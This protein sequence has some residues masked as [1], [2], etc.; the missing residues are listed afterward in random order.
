MSKTFV[1]ERTVK[2]ESKSKSSEDWDSSSVVSDAS[3]GSVY[4]KDE[5]CGLI[6]A[7]NGISS[8]VWSF[9]FLNALSISSSGFHTLGTPASS[10]LKRSSK[11]DLSLPRMTG[12]AVCS[13]ILARKDNHAR[14][15]SVARD[16]WFSSS[17]QLRP[18]INIY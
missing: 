9:A 2:D 11:C 8:R 3:A 17:V 1:S 12:S 14:L 15:R 13:S 10:Y 6:L 4:S 5:S 18:Y 7:Y 16:N